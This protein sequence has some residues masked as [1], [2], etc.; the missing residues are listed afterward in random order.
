MIRIPLDLSRH[1]IE[2]EVKRRFNR[3]LSGYLKAKGNR[4]ELEKELVLLQTALA[5]FDFSYLR[6]SHKDLAGNSAVRVEL[7]DNGGDL[8]VLT[9]DGRPIASRPHYPD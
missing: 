3:T 8:P 1:C 6:T 7:I 9:V 4:A 2:T 5:E